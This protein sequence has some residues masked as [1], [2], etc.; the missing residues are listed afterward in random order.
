[1]PPRKNVQRKKRV[2]TRPDSLTTQSAEPVSA[3]ESNPLNDRVDR[4]AHV[5]DGEEISK[6]DEGSWVEGPASSEHSREKSRTKRKVLR[7][8][9]YREVKKR[10][11]WVR[12]GGPDDPVIAE[13]PCYMAAPLPRNK[14]RYVLAFPNRPT[15]IGPPREETGDHPLEFRIKQKAGFIE[16]DVPINTSVHYNKKRG[17]M[18]GE[19]LAKSET[20]RQGGSY[21]VQGGLF[22]PELQRGSKKAADDD[23]EAD[24]GD[25]EDEENEAEGGEV[26]EEVDAYDIDDDEIDRRN[27]ER[28]RRRSHSGDER[29]DNAQEDRQEEGA[30]GN[31]EEGAA[32][33]GDDDDPPTDELEEIGSDEEEVGEDDEAMEDDDLGNGASDEDGD[34]DAMDVDADDK[35][36]QGA[37]LRREARRPLAG[38]SNGPNNNSV[39]SSTGFESDEDSGDDRPLM[40]HYTLGGW[41]VRSLKPY[42]ART[43]LMRL[44]DGKQSLAW[45][46]F[47]STLIIY[48]Q[49]GKVHF[50]PV[51]GVC[52][53]W[54]VPHHID[55]LNEQ[56]RLEK[57]DL[58]GGDA[59]MASGPARAVNMK[60]K[61]ADTEKGPPPVSSNQ[62]M[63]QD[64]RDEEW[65]HYDI[66]D[67]D[68]SYSRIDFL[69]SNLTLS[70]T[71]PPDK[72]TPRQIRPPPRSRQ[73]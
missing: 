5:S 37:R 68:V 41:I 53:M 7:G 61:S 20:Y 33:I 9:R 38:G 13:Y 66:A 42:A 43:F 52:Y 31:D 59:S 27:K 15:H 23:D 60:A 2:P 19:A 28:E 3:D 48:Y 10:N 8:T 16:M 14:K 46:V 34:E 39:N 32:D 45:L 44:K 51:D 22:R 17:R 65:K 64:L 1:M 72:R 49:T 12:P 57:G 11:K 30:G 47:R 71:G 67:R 55:A 63:L 36:G 69:L 58:A 73:C 40:D 29:E 18:Y 21:G 70:S 25:E 50:A 54:P 24:S 35:Q 26:E 6:S 4:H 56:R 62:K